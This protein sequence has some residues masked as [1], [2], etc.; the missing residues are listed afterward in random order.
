MR[1]PNPFQKYLT[2]EDLQHIQVVNFCRDRLHENVVWFHVGN[3]SKKSA[4]ERYKYSI[5]GNLSGVPDFVFLYPKY[6]EVKIDENG[7]KY[8]DLIY[9]GLV[10]ELKAQEHNRIVMKGKNAGKVVKT[11]GSVSDKQK[12]VIEKLT[13]LGYKAVVAWGAEEAISIIKEYFTLK[14]NDILGLNI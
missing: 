6:T 10:I 13:K 5:M 8:R 11:K 3:E 1:K 9:V 4:F 14:N 12:E 7:N 2:F